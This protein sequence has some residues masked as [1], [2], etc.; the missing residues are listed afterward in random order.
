MGRAIVNEASPKDP[1]RRSRLWNFE[2][3]CDVLKY[4]KGTEV[5][6]V[7]S[8]YLDFSKYD[9]LTELW[10]GIQNLHNL[11]EIDLGYSDDL[12]EIP[13]L[14]RAPN[15]QI[16]NLNSCKSLR[17]LHPSVFT[18]PKLRELHLCYCTEI[19]SLKTDIH[20]KSLEVLNLSYCYSLVEF[21]VTSG[22]MTFLSLR[23]TAIHE[24]PSSIWHNSKLDYLILSECKKLNIVRKN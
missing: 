9:K 17:Q 11:V 7:I 8:F 15:L 18:S 10:D 1:G 4:N 21:S 23:G 13:D 6:E 19:K 24:F 14:S 20:S 3:V 12:I 5:V 22:E 16:V 2:D